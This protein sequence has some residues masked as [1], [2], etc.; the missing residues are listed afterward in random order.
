ML[1]DITV[2]TDTDQFCG[3][4]WDDPERGHFWVIIKDRQIAEFDRWLR[5]RGCLPDEEQE[6]FEVELEDALVAELREH[7]LAPDDLHDMNGRPITLDG[8]PAVLEPVPEAKPERS[9]AEIVPFPG[10]SK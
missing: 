8:S 1:Q 5:A 6:V 2:Y 3:W 7:W 4:G 9:S 10:R